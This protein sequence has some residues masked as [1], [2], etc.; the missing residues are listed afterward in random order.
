MRF[1]A[2]HMLTFC[3]REIIMD[4][5]NDKGA[6]K[7]PELNIDA[8]R[9]LCDSGKIKWTTHVTMRLQERLIFRDDVFHV[10]YYG[11]IIEQ[12]PHSFPNPA[13]LIFGKTLK[14]MPLHVVIGSDGVI[15]TVITAYMPSTDKFEKD[16]ETRKEK[17]P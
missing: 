2:A 4:L 10:I 8:L 17:Q 14:G 5:Y 16:L 9:K 1:E 13:C 6:D 3:S 7:M 11:K 15:L 12:Y